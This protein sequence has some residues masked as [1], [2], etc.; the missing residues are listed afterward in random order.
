MSKEYREASELDCLR[1]SQ[2][3]VD[4]G[5]FNYQLGFPEVCTDQYIPAKLTG[6]QIQKAASPT[7]PLRAK[8]LGDRGLTLP[9]TLADQWT[10]IE[11]FSYKAILRPFKDHVT[12]LNKVIPLLH[13]YGEQ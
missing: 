2:T 3:L 7:Q 1:Y 10:R 5:F 4:L 13:I 11:P 9:R 12:P 6:T 8:D